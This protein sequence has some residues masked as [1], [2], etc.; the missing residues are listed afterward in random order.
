MSTN[1]RQ[2]IFAYNHASWYVDEVLTTAQQY[3]K[4]PDDL[5]G[6]L[7]GLTAGDRF[8]IAAKSR[9]AEPAPSP[10]PGAK[11]GVTGP[12]PS[13]AVTSFGRGTV[14]LNSG[15][16][17]AVGQEPQ[18]REA[19]SAL[20]AEIGKPVYVISGYRTPAHSVA[21]GGFPDDP[22][23]KGIAADIGVGSPTRDS[24]ASVT[25]AQLRRVGLYR[26]FSAPAEINHVQLLNGKVSTALSPLAI[27]IYSQEGAPV[28]AVNDGTV[29]QI[30]HTKKLGN[31]IV[32]QDDY[33]NKFI[34]T[35][36][37]SIRP[38]KKQASKGR[39]HRQGTEAS[40]HGQSD[41]KAKSTAKPKI[42]RT[43]PNRRRLFALPERPHNVGAA[44]LFGQ[45][46]PSM[47]MAGDE[48]RSSSGSQPHRATGAL[49]R[50][51]RVSAGTLLGRVGK[52]DNGAPHINFAIQPTGIGKGSIDPKPI[53]DGWQLLHETSVYSAGQN[54]LS[55]AAK[56]SDA[57]GDLLMPSSALADRALSSPRLE[58]YRC[59]R[60]DIRRGTIDRRVLATMN[61]LADNGFRLEISSLRCDPH[62]QHSSKGSGTA[63]QV[64]TE[65]SKRHRNGDLEDRRPSGRR[66]PGA[67]QRRRRAHQDRPRPAGDHGAG[68]G[69]L[70]RGPARAGEL[71]GFRQ[72][73]R[74][75]SISASRR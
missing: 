16:N 21:V 43:Q 57:I 51:T 52:P 66:S 49:H 29:K 50:G 62:R 48:P 65:H 7:T 12:A 54:P 15:V 8:P 72:A 30:G 24:V 42:S 25:D 69:D 3:G 11:G 74:S 27:D 70:T 73:W 23:T 38:A 59:G 64:Q 34:Y 45:L 17:M 37:G 46:Q 71:V 55:K 39:H 40:G 5:V 75:A 19:L 41:A 14:H 58:I 47:L 20:S 56:P 1:L 18:I 68:P 10:I 63:S 67:R 28:V 44:A 32:L 35:Q 31:Y 33:G 61:F 4:L 13:K 9:Y 2:A 53:L 36:L 6:S 60:L 22:H 26:P